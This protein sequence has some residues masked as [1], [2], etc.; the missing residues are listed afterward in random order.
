MTESDPARANADF[1]LRHAAPGRIGLSGGRDWVNKL[2]RKAQA[3]LTGDGHRSLWSH[4][5]LFL[6]QRIDGH[7][8][9]LE[10]D[11]DLR[12]RQ[13]RLGVQENRLARYFD[14]EMFPN[15]AVLDFGLSAAQTQQVQVAGLDVLAGLSSYSLSELVGTLFAMHS[16]HL[17]QRDNLLS[18]EGALYCSALVQHCYAAAGVHFIP[19]VAGKNIA[20]HDI[21]D[22]A[23]PHQSHSLIRDLGI[24]TA[25]RWLHGAQE[26][27]DEEPARD[28]A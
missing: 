28:P 26:W 4:A 27:L 7:W 19:G 6:E 21:Y 2:I 23:V 1:L 15:V 24:S 11:L 18:K 3:P 16:T 14:A 10:S 17:R 20:P 12:Y 5:F 8:W 9:V 22:S 13:I 25:R